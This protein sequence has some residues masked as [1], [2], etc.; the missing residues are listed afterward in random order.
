LNE[1]REMMKK[2]AEHD[3]KLKA[4]NLDQILKKL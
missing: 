2:V 4:M 1:L 3:E